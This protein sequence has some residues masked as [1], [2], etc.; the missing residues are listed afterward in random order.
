MMMNKNWQIKYVKAFYDISGELDE[1]NEKELSTF[2]NNMYMLFMTGIVLG[3]LL[4]FM[5]NTDCVSDHVSSI[6]LLSVPTRAGDS[7][8]GTRYL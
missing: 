4:S 7:S 2:G 3:F 1:F 5:F 8:F 6:L